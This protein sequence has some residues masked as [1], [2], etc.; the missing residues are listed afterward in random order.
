M[1]PSSTPNLNPERDDK[2]YAKSSADSERGLTAKVISL[3]NEEMD[4]IFNERFA[5]AANDGV[6]NVIGSIGAENLVNN[7]AATTDNMVP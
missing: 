6:F 1:N 4:R 7:L 3:T 2:Y 5:N